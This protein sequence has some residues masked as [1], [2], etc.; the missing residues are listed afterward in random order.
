MFKVAGIDHI[1]LRTENKQ[2]L[3]NFYEGVL[4]CEIERDTP[5]EIGLT[6][7]RAGNALIDIVAVNSKLGTIGG[8]APS[9]QGNNLD[10]FCLQLEPVAEEDIR[11]HLV[12]HGIVVGNF[13]ARY[14]A[15]G[16]GRS[17]YIEDPDG[18]TVELR[19]RQA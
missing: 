6:Q 17:V 16:H 1:V 9:A 18:N 3:I 13:A 8:P 11:S 19:A 2:A 7:L 5:S 15:E 10:H 4:G 12:S 14:G